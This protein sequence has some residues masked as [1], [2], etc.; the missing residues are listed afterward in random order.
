M[1]E[2]HYFYDDYVSFNLFTK[3]SLHY[4]PTIYPN[5]HIHYP[6]FFTGTSTAGIF[7]A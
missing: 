6:P 2:I 3:L 4:E 7:P 5:N 1:K